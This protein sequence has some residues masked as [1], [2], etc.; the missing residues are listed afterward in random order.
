MNRPPLQRFT[1]NDLRAARTSGAKI[2]MLTCYDYTTARLMHDAGIPMLLVGDSAANV[3]LGH[4]STVPIQLDFLIELTAAV[5]RGAPNSLVMGDMPFGSTHAS[6]EQ[7]VM[8][9]VRMVQLSGCDCVKI[10]VAASHGALVRQL[11]DAGVAVVAHLGLRPQ[12]VGVLGGYKAQGRTAAA[13]E[14]IIELA[15]RM[16]DHGAAALLVEA[17][18]S[19][20]STAIVSAVEIPVIGCGAGPACHAQ[21]VVT[22]DLWRL[23]PSQPKFVPDFG[24]AGPTLK[25]IVSRYVDEVAAGRFPANNHNY[26]MPAAELERFSSTRGK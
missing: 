2:S 9:V 20:V 6:V 3:I 5:R 26:E 14:A 4:A 11:T 15:E 13:A 16:E 8:N 25:Q 22:Q 17:V 1:L 12:S 7:G 18:P 10:E 19:A 24:A 23:T 21:V